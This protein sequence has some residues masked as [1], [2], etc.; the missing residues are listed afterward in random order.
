[1]DNFVGK[2]IRDVANMPDGKQ[3]EVFRAIASFPAITLPVLEMTSIEIADVVESSCT[4]PLQE[5]R[6]V[7]PAR[8]RATKRTLLTDSECGVEDDGEDEREEERLQ[9]NR[10]KVRLQT[11]CPIS[12]LFF[13]SQACLS[14]TMCI[15]YVA[16][17]D[18]CKI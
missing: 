3:I 14:I 12:T 13:P 6:T 8:T 18:C 11:W 9:T 15:N 16:K 2:V 7:K 1:M 17:Y 10:R 4:L 5:P